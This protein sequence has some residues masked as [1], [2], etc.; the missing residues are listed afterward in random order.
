MNYRQIFAFMFVFMIVSISVRAEVP[1]VISYQGK[2]TDNGGNPIA[3][4]AYLVKFIIYDS[5]AGGTDLWNSGY[6]NISTANGL[7]TYNLGSAVPLSDG[8]F[9]DTSL[10]LGITVGVDP[11]ITPRTRLVSV[12]F[13]YHAQK[14]DT[15]SYS[16]SSTGVTQHFEQGNTIVSGY[17][18]ILNQDSIF[19]PSAGLVMAT[20]TTGLSCSHA[21]GYDDALSLFI[22]DSTLSVTQDQA[23][24]SWEIPTTSASAFYSTL[25]EV[26]RVFPVVVGWNKFSVVGY[27]NPAGVY[28]AFSATDVTFSLL[29]IPRAL[30]TVDIASPAKANSPLLNL[31]IKKLK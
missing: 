16:K 9:S 2:L 12:P 15:A 3:D 23:N 14:A 11:E 26:H 30:G 17:L 7:F 29:F 20:V 22:L 24:R 18:T 21:S 10:Y 27:E 25:A 8:I 6:Q 28:N 13:A 4:G 31:P 5:P 1:K 19:C